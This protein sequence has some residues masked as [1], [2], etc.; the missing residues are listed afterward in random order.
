MSSGEKLWCDLLRYLM[1][2]NKR[3]EPNQYNKVQQ[4]FSYKF[5]GREVVEI[6]LSV[7]SKKKNA[8]IRF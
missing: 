1:V 3:C 4:S 6:T 8:R 7:K 2:I 5:K